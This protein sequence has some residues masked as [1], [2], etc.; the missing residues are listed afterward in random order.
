MSPHGLTRG[1]RPLRLFHGHPDDV[2]AVNALLMAELL[3]F[4]EPF[5]SHVPKQGP[6]THRLLQVPA[7]KADIKFTFWKI[8][9]WKTLPRFLICLN[10]FLFCSGTRYGAGATHWMRCSSPFFSSA[11][12]FNTSWM[13]SCSSSVR[14][15]R[16]IMVAAP[17]VVLEDFWG[18]DEPDH[19]RKTIVNG[20]YR[21]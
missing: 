18:S 10:G 15:L 11:S 12:L 3:G 13:I 19:L 21:F 8:I 2:G 20:H 14:K 1:W 5:S 6:V 4:V 9:S 7:H 16:S 17:A